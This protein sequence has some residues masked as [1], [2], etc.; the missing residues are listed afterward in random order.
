MNSS[1]IFF[2]RSRF[3][4]SRGLSYVVLAI[5]T[6][7]G[8]ALLVW[9]AGLALGMA[10]PATNPFLVGLGIFVLAVVFHPLRTW[11][12]SRFDAAFSRDPQ[13]YRERSQAFARQLTVT[14]AL[15]AIVEAIRGVL[16]D[17]V[18]PQ[19]MHL[20]LFNL[21]TDRYDTVLR[22]QGI[23]STDVEFMRESPLVEM[24]Q[25]TPEPLYLSPDVPLP[26][27]LTPETGPLGVLGAVVFVPIMSTQRLVGWLALGQRQGGQGYDESDLGFLT[28]LADQVSLAVE[29][30]QVVADLEQRVNELNVI[31]Q[32]SQAANF[33]ITRGDLL[34]LIYSQTIRVLPAQNFYI[35]LL[36]DRTNTLSY[37]YYV[38]GGERIAG[39]E[40]RPWDVG[41]GL[42][43]AVLRTSQPLLADNYM[44]AC[45]EYSVLPRRTTTTAWMG[46][47]LTTDRGPLG[48]MCVF[49]TV[50]GAKFT[51]AQLRAF[52]AL[53]DHSATAV[54]KADLYQ[55][56]VRRAR[57]LATL[58][59][60]SKV[61]SSTLDLR[62][63]LNIILNSA[64][65]LLESE[66]GSLFLTDPGSGEHVFEVI[67]GPIA[68]RA[69]I[70]TRIPARRGI[71][72]AAASSGKTVTVNDAAKDQR[73]FAE[74]DRTSGF[75]TR[76]LIATP[77]RVGERTVG[78]IEIINKRAV[79]G[80]TAED[81][82]L[83][84]SFAS[85]AA[86]AI[87]NARLFSQ[88]DEAL[89]AR[90]HELSEMQRIVRQLNAELDLTRVLDITLRYALENTG[91]EAGMVAVLEDDML[92]TLVYRGYD[93]AAIAPWQAGVRV[94]EAG[95]LGTAVETRN[96]VLEGNLDQL[97]GAV[98]V[99]REA[100]GQLV[101][102]IRREARVLAVLVLES[103]IIGRLDD[104]A[105]AFISRLSDN[106]AIAAANAQLVRAV[107]AA[108]KAKSELVGDVAHELKNPMTSIKGN[109]NLLMSG[110][111]GQIS[112]MQKELLQ[113]VARNVVRME[114]LVLDLTEV[115]RIETGQ[116]RLELAAVDFSEII[117]EAMPTLQ[118]QIEAKG[119]QLNEHLADD[120]PKAWADRRRLT[121]ILVNLLSN[122]NKYTLENR[123]IDL[124]VRPAE[125]VWDPNG[126]P[127]VLHISVADQGIG[128]LD[129]DK[130]KIFGKF[131][132]AK[133]KAT[134]DVS[135]TGLGLNIVKTLVEMQGGQ[136][137]FDSVYGQGSTFH[138]TVPLLR[139]VDPEQAAL[140]EAAAAAD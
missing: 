133:D 40:N 138:F 36:D 82:D 119:Q 30:A 58:N 45:A 69:L 117:A 67:V 99:T 113:V 4:V 14:V 23:R 132:R 37:A 124:Y 130:D 8:Y 77:L 115:T 50:A 127:E 71:V 118:V 31:N 134:E 70:G 112:D 91:A 10:V 121:Q 27:S 81:E 73:F 24:L 35:A 59:E 65:T 94:D 96:V 120:L 90:V 80:F 9:A 109:T 32:L 11:L 110:F 107:N 84:V 64:V 43:S 25:Q 29:R 21:D 88:T 128:I 54:A 3:T 104:E 114:N 101:A 74:I 16:N 5:M 26:N 102:P 116:M 97:E 48:V 93:E 131:F 136:V 111:A 92:R 76:N 34:D 103:T 122:A 39:Y 60:V 75:I 46:V 44:R 7:V 98:R 51:N 72:G 28:A 13:V 17:T 126:A 106:A 49:S 89:E 108:N 38:E 66:A 15:P 79:Q 12:Q 129:V 56:T 78:V 19:H 2:T 33:N 41:L 95:L 85:Q 22:P 123:Q 55:Q 18:R 87:E 57:Q 63:L 105:V 83:L 137:W 61:L 6:V 20:F 140:E 53:A 125:N 68:D 42:S 52:S 139:A 1:P 100:V 47:P 62:P 135:G 86:V